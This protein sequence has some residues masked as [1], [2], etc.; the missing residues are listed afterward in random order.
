MPSASQTTDS[1]PNRRRTREP[2]HSAQALRQFGS[3]CAQAHVAKNL[4]IVLQNKYIR[5]FNGEQNGV[6]R[7]DVGEFG[8]V[9]M[10][11]CAFQDGAGVRL[12]CV[13]KTLR[14][15]LN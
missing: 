9:S 14:L 15:L 3:D 12:L 4:R 7:C 10:C 1:T 13:S 5:N 2:R 11:S 8:D 6:V